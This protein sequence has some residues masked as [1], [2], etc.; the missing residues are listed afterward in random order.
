MKFNSKPSDE[1]GELQCFQKGRIL[2]FTQ[3]RYQPSGKVVATYTVRF[4]Y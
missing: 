4:D 2:W 1:I 3:C